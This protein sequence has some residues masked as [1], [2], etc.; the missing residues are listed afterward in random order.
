ML[1]RLDSRRQVQ[2]PLGVSRSSPEGC[3]PPAP[4]PRITQFS[5]L[6]EKQP[7]REVRGPARTQCEPT[8]FLAPRG[9]PPAPAERRGVLWREGGGRLSE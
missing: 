5:L 3:F 2:G 4:A 6:L 1:T 9:F 7:S 8:Q